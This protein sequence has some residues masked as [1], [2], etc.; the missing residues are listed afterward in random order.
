MAPPMKSARASAV[1][2]LFA[3]LVASSA[4]A[5]S[6]GSCDDEYQAETRRISREHIEEAKGCGGDGPCIAKA[7]QKKGKAV[8]AA[9]K[10]K[11]E[12]L[13][14]QKAELD[15][16]TPKPAKWTDNEGNQHDAGNKY[17]IKAPGGETIAFPLWFRDIG[18]T[19]NKWLL[20]KQTVKVL[21]TESGGRTSY[22]A[23]GTYHREGQ[24]A[25]T[26]VRNGTIL[27]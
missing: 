15:P 9:G 23:I 12:C 26:Q 2:V 5:Q 22:Y 27:P 4:H 16:R 8:H 24:P 11:F 25:N 10:K 6:A 3:A 17:T 18:G 20:E 13:K 14:S 1:L 19:G 7:N 21:S